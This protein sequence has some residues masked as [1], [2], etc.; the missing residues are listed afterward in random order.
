MT[1]LQEQTGWRA[2]AAHVCR[3]GAGV[4]RAAQPRP[5]SF[6]V[7]KEGCL[8]DASMTVTLFTDVTLFL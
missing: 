3:E 7:F 2:G 5:G 4:E 8:L 1:G 6:C